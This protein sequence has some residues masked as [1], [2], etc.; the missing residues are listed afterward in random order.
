MTTGD[1]I[2]PRV[3]LEVKYRASHAVCTLANGVRV[4]AKKERK[5]AVTVLQEK[6]AKSRLWCVDERDLYD[7]ACEILEASA[8]EEDEVADGY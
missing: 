7:F 2:H 5:L 8:L 4:K 6:G 1:V 3:Y